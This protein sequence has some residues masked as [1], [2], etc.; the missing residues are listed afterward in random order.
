[1]L[2]RL[3]ASCCSHGHSHLALPCSR[4]FFRPGETVSGVAVGSAGVKYA[5]P[6]LMPP[7]AYVAVACR[8]AGGAEPW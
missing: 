8:W 1:M 5:A 4:L 7:W 2:A 3:L 6:L